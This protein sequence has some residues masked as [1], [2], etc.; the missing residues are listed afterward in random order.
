MINK[1]ASLTPEALHV[2]RDKGTEVPYSHAYEAVREGTYLCRQCGLAL[3][4]GTGQFHSGCGWPSFDEEI[5]T[6]I[7]EIP[8][9]DGQRTEILCRRCNAHL[10]HVFRG[11]QFTLKNT[12]YCVN[13]I[14]LDFVLN[15]TVQDS[16]EAI[17]AAGCFWGVEA[18]FKNLPAVLKT[19]VGY[20]GGHI[21]HPSYEEI[22]RHDTGHYEVVRVVYDP[23]QISYEAV[24]KYFFEIHDF[25]QNDGQ[26]PD[27]GQQYQSRIFYYNAKQ[28][29]VAE[30]LIDWLQTQDYHVATQLLAVSTFWPAE[31]YHQDYYA[32]TKHEP[33]C[34]RYR[35]IFK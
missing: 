14:S 27:I 21:D 2:I 23:A 24:C 30:A 11:E 10:G 19:E 4:R 31:P 5:A 6:N 3:F 1:K 17:F 16:E 8:D 33:Y 7:K 29:Q 28:K 15:Q 20:S 26:G 13:G 22:C 9:R 18:L 32:K 12:R 35:Q 25:T 34:H